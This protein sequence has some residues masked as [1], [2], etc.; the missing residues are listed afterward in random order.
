MS[1]L[2]ELAELASL[3]QGDLD[4][5][6]ATVARAMASALVRGH[7]RQHLSPA[8]WEDAVLPV[9]WDSESGWHVQLPERP[10]TEVTDVAVNGAA[11]TWTLDA[12]R[13]RVVL[14]AGLP[15][16][17]ETGVADQATVSYSSGCEADAT[18]WDDAKAVAVAVAARLYR[19]SDGL[20][21]QSVDDYSET[22]AGSD[23]HLAGIA[24]T[25]GERFIL[26]RHRRTA[27]S[28]RLA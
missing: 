17:A 21:S 19:N 28:L 24:L 5:A 15:A 8:D 16:A 9:C 23:D 14:T 27:G 6:T 1:E 3:V 20:R 22:R 2:F 13:S 11:A 18:T 7:C 4:T 12:L 10:V 25:D 26:R